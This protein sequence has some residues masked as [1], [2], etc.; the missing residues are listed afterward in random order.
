MV[1]GLILPP[2]LNGQYWHLFN[3]NLKYTVEILPPHK[4]KNLKISTYLFYNR[5]MGFASRKFLFYPVDYRASRTIF[6]YSRLPTE[7]RKQASDLINPG[8]EIVWSY[9]SVAQRLKFELRD[10]KSPALDGAKVL[11]TRGLYVYLL[12]EYYQGKHIRTVLP[13][14]QQSSSFFLSFFNFL[15]KLFRIVDLSLIDFL[16]QHTR[17]YTGLVGL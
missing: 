15:V 7:D 8:F 2:S 17:D 3:Q 1:S 4:M 10:K 6:Q 9:K 14:H 11:I 16:N 13:Y 12:V 5:L